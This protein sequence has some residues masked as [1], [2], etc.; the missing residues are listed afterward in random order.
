MRQRHPAG[1]VCNAI[2]TVFPG[3]AGRGALRERVVPGQACVYP[4]TGD[5]VPDAVSVAVSE[6]QQD[7]HEREE[8][9]PGDTEGG[10]GEN[11]AEDDPEVDEECHAAVGA[12]EAET[13]GDRGEGIDLLV[14][15]EEV[16]KVR[17][18]P[19]DRASPAA[20]SGLNS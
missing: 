4:L 2:I 18:E 15:D 16:R 6:T 14:D 3:A 7:G 20:F 8:P 19:E 12:D 5:K 11:G 17:K 10:H 1:F 9:D 13:A